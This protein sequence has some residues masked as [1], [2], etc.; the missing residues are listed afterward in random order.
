MIREKRQ[1]ASPT[2]STPTQTP[3]MTA[4]DMLIPRKIM[5]GK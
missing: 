1:A 2:L 5:L 4:T 3:E